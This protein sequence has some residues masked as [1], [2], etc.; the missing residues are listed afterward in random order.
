MN[1]DTRASTTAKAT[2]ELDVRLDTA[3]AGRV[4][5]LDLEMCSCVEDDIQG[6]YL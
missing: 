2:I 5:H 6:M 1:I 3:A 4:V